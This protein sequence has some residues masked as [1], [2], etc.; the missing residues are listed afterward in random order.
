M[1]IMDG[2]R[3]GI[4]IDKTWYQE[5]IKEQK[6]DGAIDYTAF[7]AK[8]FQ[9]IHTSVKIYVEPCIFGSY[10]FLSISAAYKPEAKKY[11]LF[12][13]CQ[14]SAIGMELMSDDEKLVE[15][16]M[17]MD[18]RTEFDAKKLL[19]YLWRRVGATF[20]FECWRAPDFVKQCEKEEKASLQKLVE[21]MDSIEEWNVIDYA[22]ILSEQKTTYVEDDFY[23]NKDEN[24]TI[25]CWKQ[26]QYPKTILGHPIYLNLKK[27]NWD[28]VDHLLNTD[29]EYMTLDK[30]YGDN[31]I[32]YFGIDELEDEQL[33]NEFWKFMMAHGVK[34]NTMNLDDE[35]LLESGGYLNINDYFNESGEIK[36]W[37]KEFLRLDDACDTPW[38]LKVTYGSSYVQDMIDESLNL[39]NEHKDED[40]KQYKKLAD[41][42][43]TL[44][45]VRR[46]KCKYLI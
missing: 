37:V 32:I 17:V 28:Y 18:R 14:D 4:N 33:E 20:G 31:N 46:L 7:A 39:S 24:D 13:C 22:N 15:V 23:Q 11:Y 3:E 36:W 26:R 40:I 41:Y 5:T 35:H 42:M 21:W 1:Y 30:P 2:L 16:Q 44:F 12:E 34:Y 29:M 19:E 6:C 10:T 27:R 8:F 38:A 45:G 43:I 25:A 9:H